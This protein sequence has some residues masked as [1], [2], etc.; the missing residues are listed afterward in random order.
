MK[1]VHYIPLKL[2]GQ[3]VTENYIPILNLMSRDIVFNQDF[4]YSDE[5]LVEGREGS[6]IF[7][8]DFFS[9]KGS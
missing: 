6:L 7:N 9:C 4:F 8:R 3:D 5:G 1:I 2:S